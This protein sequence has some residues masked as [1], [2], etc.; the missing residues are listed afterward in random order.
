MTLTQEQLWKLD[1]RC[2]ELMGWNPNDATR[3]HWCPQKEGPWIPVRVYNKEF[4]PTANVADAMELAKKLNISVIHSE[5][6]V[7]AIK[8]ED[9]EHG[10]VKG[11]DYPTLT[12]VGR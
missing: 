5:D 12:L 8:P 3:A 9:I 1:A 7:Y 4:H 11:T 10:C 6:G 2:A